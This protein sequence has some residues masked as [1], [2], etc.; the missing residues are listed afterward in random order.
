M[1]FVSTQRPEIFCKSQSVGLTIGCM[2][3]DLE[4]LALQDE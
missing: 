3:R 4:M 1:N 2:Q